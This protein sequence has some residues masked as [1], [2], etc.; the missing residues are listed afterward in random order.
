MPSWTKNTEKVFTSIDCVDMISRFGGKLL[1]GIVSL[2]Q[3]VLRNSWTHKCNNIT[4]VTT[5]ALMYST[6]TTGIRWISDQVAF[7]PRPYKM[8]NI[9]T[10]W[11]WNSKFLRQRIFGIECLSP[12][13]QSEIFQILD[14]FVYQ[15]YTL[16]KVYQ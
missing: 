4:C 13:R 16:T 11:P 6:S 1:F 9:K 3:R 5:L 8:E 12:S 14:G 7:C 10:T 15:I 2:S